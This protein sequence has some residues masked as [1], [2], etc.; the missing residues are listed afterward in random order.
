MMNDLLKGPR[1]H[2]HGDV[3]WHFGEKAENML[4]AAV[5][6]RRREEGRM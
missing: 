3:L 4:A 1:R 5:A 6:C 2:L